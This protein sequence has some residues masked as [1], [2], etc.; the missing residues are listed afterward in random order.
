MEAVGA[1][2][3]SAAL[4]SGWQSA[5]IPSQCRSMRATNASMGLR[6]CHHSDARH[7]SKN[8][9]PT[10]PAGSPQLP[11]LF[12]QHAPRVQPLVRR[13]QR[14]EALPFLGREILRCESRTYFWPLSPRIVR[15][16]DPA[17]VVRMF[18]MTVEALGESRRVRP[19][20]Y[21]TASL[22]A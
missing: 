1:T 17:A 20:Q 5:A 14:L 10:A 16:R 8:A 19:R 7:C 3:P 22:P 21:C 15:S 11:E 18:G 6:R 12:L 2:K 4:F 13:Q 9:A